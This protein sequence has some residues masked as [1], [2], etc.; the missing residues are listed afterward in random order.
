MSVMKYTGR[1]REGK[2]RG[3]SE[4]DGLGASNNFEGGSQLASDAALIEELLQVRQGT[5]SIVASDVPVV[6]SLL[7]AAQPT[8]GDAASPPASS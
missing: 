8:A 3:S 1:P 2:G 6:A 4:A 5:A 7:A